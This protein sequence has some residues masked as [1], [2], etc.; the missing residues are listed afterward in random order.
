[1]R[2]GKGARERE[3]RWCDEREQRR[4]EK[5]KEVGADDR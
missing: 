2:G 4:R 3:K 1:M 5:K